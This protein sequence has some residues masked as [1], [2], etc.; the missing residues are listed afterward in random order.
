M[1]SFMS[2]PDRFTP[3]GEQETVS[4]L[5]VLTETQ[6]RAA[7]AIV[8][9]LD[10]LPDVGVVILEGISGVGKTRVINAIK[11]EIEARGASIDD[12]LW[13]TDEINPRR[14][15]IG[16]KV[17]AP[18]TVRDVKTLIDKLKE[19][20]PS[21]QIAQCVLQA[22]TLE[23]SLELVRALRG[24]RQTKLTDEEIANL[25]LGIPLLIERLLADP[26]L[27]R[28]EAIQ[29]A[30]NHIGWDLRFSEY[31][32]RNG[33]SRFLQIEPSQQIIDIA[34]RTAYYPDSYY[35]RLGYILSMRETLRKEGIFEESPRF[36]APES[37]QIYEEMSRVNDPN[38]NPDINIFAPEINVEDFLRIA[39]AL[40]EKPNNYP[41]NDGSRYRMFGHM[42]RKFAIWMR[43][44]VNAETFQD[45]E[46][47]DY[48]IIAR[49]AEED[50]LKGLLPLKPKKRR[51]PR[52]YFHQHDHFGLTGLAFMSGWM[53][54]SLLQQ[55][56]IPYLVD[57]TVIKKTYVYHPE[58]QSIEYVEF[59]IDKDP[60]T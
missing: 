18:T 40:L 39:E 48:Q 44:A 27:P 22:T 28:D 56:G 26:W 37:A 3:K 2:S 32:V 36:I 9:S 6:Q 53:V 11:N 10:Q 12:N 59:N 31:G 46:S 49:K 55:R 7:R 52:F 23:E 21:M 50:F 43:R 24:G 30:G 41:L 45:T 38:A 4:G 8:S 1:I 16:H 58:S 14:F 25:S 33:A 17:V 15:R 19:K 51:S 54:E 42:Y 20:F 13:L 5:S 29:I 34:N 60:Y 57:N 35:E 47:E